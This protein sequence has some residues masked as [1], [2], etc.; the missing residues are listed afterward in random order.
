MATQIPKLRVPLQIRGDG[1]GLAVV[2]QDSQADV[3]QCVYAILATP[4]GSRLEEPDFG[5]EDPTFEQLPV[6]LTEWRRTITEWEPRAEI[7][8]TEQELVDDV[9]NIRIEVA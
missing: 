6:D 9:T 5:I 4:L 3:A 7:D 8:D 2:E 1:T